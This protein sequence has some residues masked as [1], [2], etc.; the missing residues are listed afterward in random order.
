MRFSA[1]L[2]PVLERNDNN[3]NGFNGE[4]NFHHTRPPP[5][6][7]FSDRRFDAATAQNLI[8]EIPVRRIFGL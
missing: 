6:I 2:P 8:R 1:H 4:A 3:V 5:G 7:E